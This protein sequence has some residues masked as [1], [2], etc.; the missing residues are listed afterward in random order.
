MAQRPWT[1]WAEKHATRL[2]W[3][4]L[5]RP[6]AIAALE[7]LDA[8]IAGADL[9]FLGEMNHFV[10][11]KSDF[12][13]FLSRYLISRGVTRFAEE[14]GWSDG[15][16][17]QRWFDT[18]D[19]SVFETLS[20]FGD[21]SDL[22]SDRDDRPTGL[23][24]A[25]FDSYPRALMRAEQERFYRG[26]RAQAEAA[27][28]RLSYFCFDIDALPGGGYRDIA[29]ALAP[30]AGRP[31]VEA[32][33][34]GLE[35]RP[36][37]SVL[38][39]ARRLE[40]LAPALET[41]DA[42]ADVLLE[43]TAALGAL[44]DSLFYV[45]RTYA[46]ETYEA[47]RP[48]MAYRETAMRRRFS[49]LQRIGPEGPIVVMSHAFH[50]AKDDRL[51]GDLPGAGPGGGSTSSIGHHLVQERGLKAFSVWLLYGGGEDSQPF[52]DLP[53]TARYPRESLNAQLGSVGAPLLIRLADVPADL[54]ATPIGVGHMYNTVTPTSLA[55][56]VDAIVFV[57]QAT[58]MR[59]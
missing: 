57:P 16:R 28:R 27:S 26:L 22:R 11:E 13:L 24:K 20:L 56:Q 5:G 1:R 12:R 58:P 47:V 32:F 37:E 18:G 6:D 48:G 9:V 45:D 21:M 35:R 41:A 52:P 59:V 30:F 8:D 55:G 25:S 2:P 29:G 15:R 19:A 10:H 44:T 23:F 49:D 54:A 40:A 46:A 33:L 31:S 14:L 17:L 34:S 38:E 50:L 36:G 53:R 42:P 39:E 7:G 4:P 51:F 43:A 3:P